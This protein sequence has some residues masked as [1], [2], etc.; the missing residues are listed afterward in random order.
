M[1]DAGLALATLEVHESK[2]DSVPFD[3]QGVP[4]AMCYRRLL[5]ECT[6]VD[7]AAGMLRTMRR[8]TRMNLAVCDKKGGAVFEITPKNVIVR[9][10]VDGFCPCTN[11]FRTPELAVDMKCRRFDALVKAKGLAKIDVSDIA[12]HL[13]DANQGEYTLQTM[14]FEPATMKLHL[15]LGPCPSSAQKLKTLDVGALLR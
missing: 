3:P 5:E 12:K 15:A 11:H 10:S 8:T 13:H 2:D 6:T 7:Q 4:Y 14:V 1:N 9:R